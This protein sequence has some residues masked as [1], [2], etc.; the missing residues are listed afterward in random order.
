MRCLLA[1]SAGLGTLVAVSVGTPGPAIA[2]AWTRPE[3]SGQFIFS[4]GR[5]TAPAGALVGGA[6]ERNLTVT[7]IYVEY[8]LFDDLTIGASAYTEFDL[9]DADEGSA[10]AAILARKRLW[11][12][13][14]GSVASVQAAFSVPFE[15]VIR[16]EFGR[17]KPDSVPELQLR[18]LYGTSWWGD[19]GNAFLSTEAGYYL[20]SEGAPDEIRLDATVGYEP[21]RCCMAL[22]SVYG[23][24]PLGH[25]TG[26]DNSSSLKI[27]PSF[28]YTL[29]PEI[30]RNAKKPP[31]PVFPSTIQ[32]G[33]DYDVLNGDDGLGLFISIWKRF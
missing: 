17:S 4:S 3:G 11:Q 10:A 29:W 6:T 18:G 2:G 15:S 22:F 31:V 30:V 32:V 20:R 7:Q 21:R 23:A 25:R 26:H 28:A 12:N 14:A 16:E 19:W 24:V 1:L 8:G 27:A 33:L 5:R 13:D 9:F